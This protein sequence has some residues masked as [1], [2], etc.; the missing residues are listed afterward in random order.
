MPSS[1]VQARL[2]TWSSCMMWRGDKLDVATQAFLFDQTCLR[3]HLGQRIG[4]LM[5]GRLSNIT[6]SVV[7]PVGMG[8][9]VTGHIVMISLMLP[10]PKSGNDR[11]LTDH[12]SICSNKIRSTSALG[13]AD[14]RQC[15][16]TAAPPAFL[17]DPRR[18]ALISQIFDLESTQAGADGTQARARLSHSKRP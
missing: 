4:K 2:A 14:R 17:C 10:S 11:A 12:G 3:P 1:S 16:G 8:R 15:A 7:R 18:S 5:L 9:F 6:D 13:C